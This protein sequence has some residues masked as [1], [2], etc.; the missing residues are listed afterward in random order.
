MPARSDELRIGT[1]RWLQAQE[2]EQAYWRRLGDSIEAGTREQLDWYKWR[3]GQLE[4]RLASLPDRGPR[5]GQVLEIGSGPI[6]IVN[7]LQWGERYAI[8]PLEHFYRTRP[9]LVSLRTDGVTYLDGTGEQLPF[10]DASCSL[11]IIDNVIDHT[12]APQKILREIQR[13]LEP[14]GRLYLSVNVHTAWGALLHEVLAILRI[15]KGHPYTFTS[16]TLRGL[17]TAH[18]FVMV[19]E[20]IED[21]GRARQSDRQSASL[22]ARIKGYTGLSEFLHSVICQKQVPGAALPSKT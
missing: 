14:D 1:S 10:E 6:G 18:Q 7:F 16:R 17:L 8:D 13:V 15:D 2:Y 11:V 5:A 22:K 4:R 9:A 12:Y 19:T 20:Q 21:Y 3:A